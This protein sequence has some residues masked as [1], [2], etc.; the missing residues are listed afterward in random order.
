MH[1]FNI[2]LLV[3]G[4][5]CYVYVLLNI[6]LFPIWYQGSNWA[7]KS[8]WAA[9]SKA[10]AVALDVAVQS[11]SCNYIWLYC[12]NRPDCYFVEEINLFSIHCTR[13]HGVKKKTLITLQRSRLLH[14]VEWRPC[15]CFSYTFFITNSR[16][17]YCWT[18]HSVPCVIIYFGSCHHLPLDNEQSISW[19]W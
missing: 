12:H 18:V 8:D 6:V 5:H 16:L 3:S 14:Q 10:T 1:I 15:G 2:R 17:Q 4:F 13:L 19:K 7:T 9:T 11:Y